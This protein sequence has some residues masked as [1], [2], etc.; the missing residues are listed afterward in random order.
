[1]ID[2]DFHCCCE[3]TVRSYQTTIQLDPYYEHY[4]TVQCWTV[5]DSYIRVH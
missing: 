5:L 4:D 3:R 1:M 2:Y